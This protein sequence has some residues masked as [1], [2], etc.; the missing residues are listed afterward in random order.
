[1]VLGVKDNKAAC[2]KF[3]DVDLESYLVVNANATSLD[4]VRDCISFLFSYD[5]EFYNSNPVRMDVLLD[6][7]VLESPLGRPAAKVKI[8][9]FADGFG[10]SPLDVKPDRSTYLEEYCA[11]LDSC[12]PKPYCPQ[13]IMDIVAE[14]I[15]VF[16]AGNRSA[17]ETA[18]MIHRRVQLYFDEQ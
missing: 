1:M 8:D 11:F 15:D 12:E 3:P 9:N 18:E 13:A 5:S 7:V 16:F 10:Y 2:E 6:Q 14:E 17:Q 4:A